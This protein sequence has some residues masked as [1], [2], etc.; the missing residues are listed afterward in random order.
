MDVADRI[1]I[2]TKLLGALRGLG[3]HS[4]DND[5]IDSLGKV[6]SLFARIAERAERSDWI[7]ETYKILTAPDSTSQTVTVAL[8]ILENFVDSLSN[9]TVNLMDI[10][11]TCFGKAVQLEA[12]RHELY[13]AVLI[14]TTRFIQCHAVSISVAKDL[15]SSIASQSVVFVSNV[16][17]NCFIFLEKLIENF[18]NH[19]NDI[20]KLLEANGFLAHLN[21]IAQEKTL[22]DVDSHAINNFL[23][24]VNQI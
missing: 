4:G 19:V 1:E 3:N 15:L 6:I 22:S 8:K 21:A 12:D 11:Q 2:R 10:I 5:L 20:L 24:K 7:K 14:F 9:E 16:R 23:Q 18:K 17:V 13:N